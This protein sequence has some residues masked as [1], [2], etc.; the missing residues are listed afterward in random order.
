MPDPDSAASRPR[1][2]VSYACEESDEHVSLVREFAA[3]LRTEA[4][5][6][7]H[8]D[9]WYADGRRD[10]V[11]WA[12]DQFQQADFIVVIASPGYGL[13][14]G[15]LDT[16]MLHDKLGR[17]LPDATHQILPVVLPG[18]S[19]TDIP[20]VLSAFAATHYVVR[21][22]SLDEVQ[23]L[24]RA[25]HGSPAHAMPPLGAFRPPDV[26]AG[27]VLVATPRSPPRTGRHLGPGAEVVIG[28]DHYLV[29]A[30]TYEETTTSDGAAVL[31]GA[32][33]LS[34][35][36]PRPQVWLR[37]LEIRQDTPMAEE[38]ATALTCERT[39]LASPAG[40]WLGILVSPAL[41]REPG[42]VTLVTGW[43]LSGRTRGP[44]DTLASFVPERGELADPLRTRA[45]LR[46]LGGLCR[47][48]AAL[49]RMDASHR[50]LAPAAI[51]RLD[52]G[53][54]AL[55]DLG[56]ATTSYEPGEGPE[57]YRAP[58][59]GRRRRGKAGP[60]TDAYQIGAIAYH[61]ATGH[62]PPSIPVPVRGLAPDLPPAATAAIDAALDA[63]PSRRPGILALGAAFDS[64]R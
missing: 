34:V 47:K 15:M 33:A 7:A 32:R 8:L 51:I 54:L 46:G 27:P 52:D 24:L 22:F 49:H 57:L 48:L 40:R 39:L 44:C 45:I 31:R 4:G 30:G 60:W 6:D 42:L 12:S 9:Q 41:V 20:H 59:Q 16:A 17:S 50:C 29:H 18:G 37:Q 35:G 58:E 19:A 14:M 2:Y 26:E 61:F 53:A 43:P 28:D 13:T 10:W 25:I 3:F 21:A 62:P 5:V 63:E 11:A 36:G 23:G 38:A 64:S 1:V 55:R 56:L